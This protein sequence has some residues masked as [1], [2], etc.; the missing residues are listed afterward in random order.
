MRFLFGVIIL[1]AAS[2]GGV[3]WYQSIHQPQKPVDVA[4][5]LKSEPEEYRRVHQAFGR[6]SSGETEELERA[7]IAYHSH[8][9]KNALRQDV[10]GLAYRAI[11]NGQDMLKSAGLPWME[12][13]TRETIDL[14][15]RYGA[16]GEAFCSLSI[17]KDHVNAE[18]VLAENRRE[19]ETIELIEEFTQARFELVVLMLEALVDGKSKP[20]ALPEVDRSELNEILISS[21]RAE[22]A[23]IIRKLKTPNWTCSEA[24][25]VLET[26]LSIENEGERY[27]TLAE[28]RTGI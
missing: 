26:A 8:R 9:N 13:I 20:V 16:Y 12:R 21:A 3:F 7:L 18:R 1:F 22:D 24:L 23:E 15:R 17:Q 4:A 28:M 2:F 19:Q 27:V 14:M 5:L 25:A 6:L 10:G 11:D